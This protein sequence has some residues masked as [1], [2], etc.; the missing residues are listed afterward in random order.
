ME[1]FDNFEDFFREQFEDFESEP[2]AQEWENIRK[3]LH[4]KRRLI[5][6][7]WMFPAAILVGASL[8]VWNMTNQK[9]YVDNPPAVLNTTKGDLKSSE[10]QLTEKNTPEKNSN[11]IAST[12]SNILDVKI[13]N[14]SKN[15]VKSSLSQKNGVKNIGLAPNGN[16]ENVSEAATEQRVIETPRITTEELSNVA[17]LNPTLIHSNIEKSIERITTTSQLEIKKTI[18]KHSIVNIFTSA[19]FSSNY[20]NINPIKDDNV[21]LSNVQIPNFTSINRLGWQANMG[22]RIPMTT[23]WSL[24]ASLSYQGFKSNIQYKLITPDVENLSGLLTS[25]GFQVSNIQYKSTEVIESKIYH[26]LGIQ[27]DLMFYFNK[28]NAITAGVSVGRLFGEKQQNTLYLN[29][30]YLHKF[31]NFSVEPF[32]RYHLKTYQTNNNYYN[33]QPYSFGINFSY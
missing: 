31:E 33:F 29:S 32:F 5:A 16:N 24:R 23:H 17:L 2:S 20:R 25:S 9:E 6:F 13:E 22:V 15:T 4:P 26:N 30:S 27:T 11:N 12:T 19:G 21:L 10:N 3:K 7:W 18:D 8:L 14:K 1:Q 28:K